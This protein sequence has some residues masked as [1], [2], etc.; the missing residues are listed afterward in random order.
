MK[1]N[2]YFFLYLFFT[3]CFISCKQEVKEKELI[4]PINQVKVFFN[5]T[6]TPYY[7][8]S[9]PTS[10]IVQFPSIDSKKSNEDIYLKD[11]VYQ[12]FSMQ[13]KLDNKEDLIGRISISTTTQIIDNNTDFISPELQIDTQKSILEPGFFEVYL[14]NEDIT[15]VFTTG[16]NVA[17]QKYTFPNTNS[18]QIIIDPI[19]K[20]AGKVIDAQLYTTSPREVLGYNVIQQN[21]K[22]V[23]VYFAIKFTKDYYGFRLIN[24][25]KISNKL[26]LN[27]KKLK[28]VATFMT[29]ENEAVE[30]KVAF[31]GKSIREAKNILRSE[32]HN[33]FSL[34][35]NNAQNEWE[36]LFGKFYLEGGSDI[37]NE[38]FY[39]GVYFSHHFNPFDKIEDYNPLMSFTSKMTTTNSY[40]KVDFAS[41]KLQQNTSIDSL[42]VEY[43]SFI[44][45]G[46]RLTDIDETYQIDAP[47]FNRISL[48][49]LNGKNLV[50]E[51]KNRTELNNKVSKVTFN[52]KKL[53]NNLITYSQ[54]MEGGI[55]KVYFDTVN[56]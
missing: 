49:L 48:D 53:N 27:S 47:I 1:K 38:K 17:F 15:A 5:T 32:S 21:N 24:D 56:N 3:F 51:A 41:K 8:V 33:S 37:Q 13:A 19:Y 35:V 11:S 31:S 20:N 14:P 29:N 18:A 50:I 55:L 45:T 36:S 39:S 30:V 25:Q 2:I 26:K 4:K 46:F 40:G 23:K 28:G 12:G 22:A 34:A 43:F 6:E 44:S 16:K 52:D 9:M 10:N 7:G 54:I 42:N